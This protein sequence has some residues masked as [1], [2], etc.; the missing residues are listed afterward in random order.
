M[1]ITIGDERYPD[2]VWRIIEH[3]E[4]G[5]VLHTYMAA[6]SAD[7]NTR[8]LLAIAQGQ[9]PKSIYDNHF[10]DNASF[11]IN[12][13]YGMYKNAE[14]LA[15]KGDWTNPKWTKILEEARRD[16]VMFVTSNFVGQFPDGEF[17]RSE[18][19]RRFC[20]G[21][22]VDPEKVAKVLGLKDDE[23][24]L[25]VLKE[26]MFLLTIGEKHRAETEM[27]KLA[28][29]HKDAAFVKHMQQALRQAGFAA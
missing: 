22:A 8:F 4:L 14:K 19:F 12:I 24:D 1:S 28:N 15:S 11:Q 23:D 2:D 26:A 25:T 6:K 16:V 18:Q 5:L 21:K 17:W 3:Q 20:F 29:K 27:E 13:P 10:K 9:A 7:E